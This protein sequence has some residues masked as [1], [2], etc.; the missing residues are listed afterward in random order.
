MKGLF[1]GARPLD[2]EFRTFL[3]VISL[4]CRDVNLVAVFGIL[5][6]GD[7]CENLVF[8]NLRALFEI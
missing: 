6:F 8:L 1:L 5:I 3:I 2:H 7:V 4:F